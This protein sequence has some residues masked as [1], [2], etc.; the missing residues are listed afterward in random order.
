MI[1]RLQTQNMEPT[2]HPESN[3]GNQSSSTKRDNNGFMTDAS[4]SAKS[5]TFQPQTQQ[6]YFSGQCRQRKKQGL[7]VCMKE[8][9]TETHDKLHNSEIYATQSEM[10]IVG[11]TSGAQVGSNVKQKH[12]KQSDTSVNKRRI[13]HFQPSGSA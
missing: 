8:G 4:S 7:A 5:L 3:V 2:P 11:C 13:H 12:G 1:P 9:S 10:A 6:S